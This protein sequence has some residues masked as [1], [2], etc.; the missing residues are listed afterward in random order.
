[1][2]SHPGSFIA[3]A[4]IAQLSKDIKRYSLITLPFI[5]L[6]FKR[7]LFACSNA[8]ARGTVCDYGGPILAET[9]GLGGPLV[10]GD[11]LFRD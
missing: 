10:A 6:T 11:H 7:A 5:T 2:M 4:T 3:V 8:C 1:M 9:D